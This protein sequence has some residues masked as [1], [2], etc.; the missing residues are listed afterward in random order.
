MHI[1]VTGGAGYIGSVV[2]EELINQGE[3]VTVLDNLA[4]GHRAAL[5]SQAAFLLADLA[6]RDTLN[7][8]FKAESFDAVEVDPRATGEVEPPLL[9][10]AAGDAPGASQGL[11]QCSRVASR[12]D[13]VP[14]QLGSALVGPLAKLAQS[15]ADT[16]AGASHSRT[17]PRA[18]RCLGPV[19]G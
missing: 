14:G 4:Q 5:H 16:A 2:V 3:Q 17:E 13:H 18:E 6:D 19:H 9:A 1:L 7:D 15:Q 12:R 10:D 8:L 11:A